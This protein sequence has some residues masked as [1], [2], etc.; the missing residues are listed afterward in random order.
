MTV[1]AGP[2]PDAQLRPGTAAALGTFPVDR[3]APRAARR[4]GNCASVTGIGSTILKSCRSRKPRKT[5]LPSRCWTSGAANSF[6]SAVNGCA[7]V[8][9]PRPER[10]VA[11][12]YQV[13]NERLA[14]RL[15]LGVAG[16]DEQPAAVDLTHLRDLELAEPR[17][18]GERR[19]QLPLDHVLARAWAR[20][21]SLKRGASG[22]RAVISMCH[23]AAGPEDE[24]VAPGLAGA[25]PSPSV[26][27]QRGSGATIG[28]SATRRQC[29][30]S[31]DSASPI[32]WS[33]TPCPPRVERRVVH[34][35][36]PVGA[37]RDRAG[38]QREIVEARSRPVA[39]ASRGPPSR[40]DRSSWRGRSAPPCGAAP[41]P[42]A[43]SAPSGRTGGSARRRRRSSCPRS[44]R[45]GPAQHR[46]GTSR[47][48]ADR[49]RR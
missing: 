30:R 13:L 25:G 36:D 40:R 49:G 4:D 27:Y 14:A 17:R 37:A 35:P 28:S 7:C 10:R 42:R 26:R 12:T 20:T 1:H 15:L 29:I 21:P 34:A 48:G 43:R 5:Q 32:R 33:R 46:T 41:G 8:D 2:R 22:S 6:G 19:P 11:D 38:P 16:E 18:L 44:S 31:P 47:S 23:V 45:S 39:S 24:R 3:A 9:V